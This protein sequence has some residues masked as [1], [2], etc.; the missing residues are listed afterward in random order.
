MV[1]VD[2]VTDKVIAEGQGTVAAILVIL[3]LSRVHIA[4]PRA[5]SIT[6]LPV[7]LHAVW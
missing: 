7:P 6:L 1:M 4:E 3:T 5:S 2:S